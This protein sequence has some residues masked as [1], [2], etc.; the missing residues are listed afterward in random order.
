AWSFPDDDFVRDGAGRVQLAPPGEPGMLLARLS[1]RTAAATDHVDPARL[2]RDA[3]EPGDLW[4]VT[5]DF[6]EVDADGDHWL[7]DRHDQMIRTRHGAVASMRIEDALYEAPGIALC[8]V[9]AAPDPEHPGFQVAVAAVQLHP[10][11]ALDLDAV[12]AAVAA[13]PEY[14]RP[15]RLRVVDE[16]PLTDGFRPIKRPV[17]ELAAA[18]GQGIYE[19]VAHVRHSTETAPGAPA[20][21]PPAH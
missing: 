11:T 9:T 21:A 3:F 12:S 5:G 17:R 18:D 6:F 2:L 8:T 7:V 10:G 15:R 20:S 13:L 4:F 1:A 16:I 14:S 19:W